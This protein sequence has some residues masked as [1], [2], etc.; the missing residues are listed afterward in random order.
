[1]KMTPEA[2]CVLVWT[3]AIGSSLGVILFIGWWVFSG[4]PEEGLALMLAAWFVMAV[5][6]VVVIVLDVPFAREM[7]G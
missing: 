5:V 4:D 1:M 3:L 6:C 7:V 2:L